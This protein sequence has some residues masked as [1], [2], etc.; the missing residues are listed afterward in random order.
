MLEVQL[1]ISTRRKVG[2][3]LKADHG[4]QNW[5]HSS[6]L[7]KE[8]KSSPAKTTVRIERPDILQVATDSDYFQQSE[9]MRL[10]YI[11]CDSR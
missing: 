5:L 9:E 1:I 2:E 10:G 7:Q 3:H 4:E 8:K 6:A 11:L